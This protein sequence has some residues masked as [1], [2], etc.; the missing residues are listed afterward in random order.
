M[1]G[2]VVILAAMVS[3]CGGETSNAPPM[4]RCEFR[5]RDDETLYICSETVVGYDDPASCNDEAAARFSWI[6]L[7]AAPGDGPC[8]DQ[9]KGRGCYFP[10]GHTTVWGYSPDGVE[11][12][13]GL[14]LTV[15]P[16]EPVDP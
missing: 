16:S 12:A 8:P 10:L 5:L 7:S 14:C 9:G 13:E 11:H 4:S 15:A 2:L 1:R 3:A 6:D